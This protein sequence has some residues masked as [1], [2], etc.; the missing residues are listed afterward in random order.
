MYVICVHRHVNSW[1]YIACVIWDQMAVWVEWRG[2]LCVACS[3]QFAQ[4]SDMYRSWKWYLYTVC[5][6][7]CLHLHICTLS[8]EGKW[9]YSGVTVLSVSYVN[10][11]RSLMYNT[12][13]HVNV[14]LAVC[15]WSMMDME[16]AIAQLGERQTEDL[17]VLGSIPSRGILFCMLSCST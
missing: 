2:Y 1:W 5:Q 9:T 3:T 16:A 4:C 17:K 7:C 14:T 11:L 6:N 12:V 15:V 13:V 8:T 10:I